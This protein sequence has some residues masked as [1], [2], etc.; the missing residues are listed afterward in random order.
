MY[1]CD[2]FNGMKT[3]LDK[4]PTNN[5]VIKDKSKGVKNFPERFT[6]FLGLRASQ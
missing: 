3:F 1:A 5:N 2:G 4:T 6:I